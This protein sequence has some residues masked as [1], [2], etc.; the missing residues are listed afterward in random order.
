MRQLFVAT[1]GVVVLGLSLAARDAQ[2]PR[3]AASP[4][5]P[6]PATTA[7][8]PPGP[9]RRRAPPRPRH[10]RWWPPNRRASSRTYCGTCH[11]ERGKAGGLSLASFDAMKA[12]E[13]P[14]VI[15]KMIRK[16]R[17]GMMPPPGAKRPE[18]A[19]I[20]Q[21]AAGARGAHGRVRG[22]QPQPRLAAVP[23]AHPRRVL[24]RRSRTC[25]TSTSTSRPYLPADTQPRLRQH[26]RSAGLLAR[27]CSTATCARPSQVS[28]LALG[29][30]QA[31]PTSAT[32]RVLAGR[33]ADALRRGH[34][35]RLARRHR[36][37]PQLPRRRRLHVHARCSSARSA[38]SCSATPAS[39]WP[40]ATSCSRFSV[41]GERAAVLE[42]TASMSDALRARLRDRHAAD[43]RQGRPAAHRRGVRAALRRPGRRPDGADRPHAGR[44]AHRHRLR[45]HG[46]CRTS[47]TW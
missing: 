18:A 11:S 22:Q 29:D 1:A 3:P 47:R 9:H 34:A 38:A 35:V 26:R 31:S 28:R 17:A 42:V 36:R 4:P 5:R 20:D 43:P 25:S 33:V 37:G 44:H 10:R 41:N 12:H 19:H 46:G 16:L 13:Q 39:P 24:S 21:L 40:A 45:H 30:K 23:A 32:Y 8:T 7:P 14:E 27:R 6:A 2:G 15:E